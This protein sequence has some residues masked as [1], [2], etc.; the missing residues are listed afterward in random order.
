MLSIR[1]LIKKETSPNEKL[2]T[3]WDDLIR[4]G[5]LKDDDIETVE[6]DPYE[7]WKW[8]R[9]FYGLLRTKFNIPLIYIYPNIIINGFTS[10]EFTEDKIVGNNQIKIIKPEVLERYYEIYLKRYSSVWLHA[11]V[12]IKNRFIAY[13]DILMPVQTIS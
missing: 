3:Y 2:L 9:N 11:T 10:Y 5:V 4:S 12:Y 13:I 8:K 7:L 1:K 6:V